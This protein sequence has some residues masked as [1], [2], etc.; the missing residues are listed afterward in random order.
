MHLLY[1]GT[2]E[3]AFAQIIDHG[4]KEGTY[5]TP[6]LDSAIC[7]GGPYVFT[8]DVGFPVDLEKWQVR[9]PAI[10][11]HHILYVQK[12]DLELV[13][14]N[15]EALYERHKKRIESEGHEICTNC[16]GRGEHRE[17]KYAY[18]YLS[19]PGGGAWKDREP[20]KVCEQCRGYGYVQN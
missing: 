11:P 8:I 16:Q 10:P 2:N 4:F 5:F 13:Y 9:M 19:K 6:F 20:I 1:H 18:R 7:F 15:K 14:L 3:E 17:D 12:F